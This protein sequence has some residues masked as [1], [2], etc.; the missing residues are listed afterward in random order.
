[1]LISEILPSGKLCNS[2]IERYDLLNLGA[3]CEACE[4][5]HK[6]HWSSHCGWCPFYSPALHTSLQH[7]VSKYCSQEPFSSTSS[8]ALTSSLPLPLLRFVFAHNCHESGLISD[9]EWS[10]YCDWH[11]FLLDALPLKFD[12]IVYLKTDPKVGRRCGR[13]RGIEER[14]GTEKRGE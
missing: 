12:G 2:N 9:T 11:S 8:T 3:G 10:I 13:R 4:L 5:C 1:M 7:T 6:L 14:E